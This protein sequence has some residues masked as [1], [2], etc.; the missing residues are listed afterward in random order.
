MSNVINLKDKVLDWQPGKGDS[1]TLKM[2]YHALQVYTH[3]ENC[4]NNIVKFKNE[5]Y[6]GIKIGDMALIRLDKIYE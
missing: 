5:E 6:N 3:I 1:N 2:R 4:E